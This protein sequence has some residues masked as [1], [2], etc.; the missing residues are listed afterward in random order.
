MDFKI[1]VLRFFVT[2]AELRSVTKASEKL[3]VAQPSL[4][5]RIRAFEEQLGFPLFE[6]AHGTIKL[7]PQ[8]KLFYPVAKKLVNS[9][10]SAGSIVR[11]LR[12]GDVGTLKVGGSWF[13]LE[14]SLCASIVDSF[15]DQYLE[16]DVIVERGIYSPNILEQLRKNGLDAAF[17]AGPVDETEFEALHLP[18]IEFEALVPETSP[19]AQYDAIPL[20]ALPGIRFAWY[21]RENN[22][23]IFDAVDVLLSENGAEIFSP[24]DTHLNALVSYAQRNQV[25]TMIGRETEVKPDGMKIIPFEGARVQFASSLVRMKSNKSVIIDKFFAHAESCLSEEINDGIFDA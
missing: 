2:V 12:S 25:H 19:L 14:R 7:S 3:F 18:P 24:P 22:P 23:H 17:V 11:N 4:S 16:I 10:D 20:E 21:R 13:N 15:A 9:A 1:R 6:R 8:G 5:Q